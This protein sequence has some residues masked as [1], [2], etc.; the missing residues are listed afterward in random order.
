[1]L[2]P[3]D[4]DEEEAAA[5]VAALTTYLNEADEEDEVPSWEGARWQFAGRVSA[6]QRREVRV[7]SSAP[8]DAWTASG[9]TDRM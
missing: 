2:V 6:L 9:R 3:D 4:A 1:M 7:P 5:I 8:R